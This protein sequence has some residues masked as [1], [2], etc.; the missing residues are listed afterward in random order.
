MF[1]QDK[2]VLS[3]RT[4]ANPLEEWGQGRR[5]LFDIHDLKRHIGNNKTEVDD[6][7]CIEDRPIQESANEFDKA[8]KSLKVKESEGAARLYRGP[9]ID[10][11]RLGNDTRNSAL[12]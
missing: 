10:G 7:Y 1:H 2:L 8:R 4:L 6:E 12:S 11:T 9:S 3:T 5:V